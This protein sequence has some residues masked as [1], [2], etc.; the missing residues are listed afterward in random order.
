MIL[1]H[2][3]D[4]YYL[5]N[6]GTILQDGLKPHSDEDLGFPLLVVWF[7]TEADPVCWWKNAKQSECR[8]TTDI[9]STDPRLVKYADWLGKNLPDAIERIRD[10]VPANAAAAALSCWYI[11]FGAVPLSE[12]QAIEH[13]D[14]KRR[15]GRG[16]GNQKGKQ[17]FKP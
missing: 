9:P 14:P 3:T 7:T 6:G 10:T 17:T 4:F 1:Y 12:L 8:V 11:Y 2:F 5:K 15:G 13:A 16:I